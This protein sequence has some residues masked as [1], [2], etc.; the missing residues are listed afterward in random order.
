MPEYIT[1][2]IT[3]MIILVLLGLLF[4]FGSNISFNITIY[5]ISLAAYLEWLRLTSN[6]IIFLF[7]FLFLLIFLN[8]VLIINLEIF[9]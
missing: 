9:S 5:A 1:R 2:I 6:S 7:P 3:S 4:Y 8:N